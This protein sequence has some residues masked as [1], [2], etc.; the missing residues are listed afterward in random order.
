MKTKQQLYDNYNEIINKINEYSDKL[1]E[2]MCNG[3]DYKERQYN[4]ELQLLGYKKDVLE[5]V[6]N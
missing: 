6:L 3:E 4:E 5:W 1:V 2:A